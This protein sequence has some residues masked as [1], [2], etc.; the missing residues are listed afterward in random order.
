[1]KKFFLISVI[2]ITALTMLGLSSLSQEPN[3]LKIFMRAKLTHSQKL[4]EG[5]TT[6]NYDELAK[7]SQELALLSQATN[8]NV[9]MTKDYLQHSLEFRR[10]ASALTKAAQEKN[11]DGATLA[12]VDMTMKCVRCHQYVRGV[13]TADIRGAF[14]SDAISLHQSGEKR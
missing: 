3:D 8:W 9:L 14:N 4:I 1:M 10:A 7:H 2:G 6:E 11:L 13:R 5:L 12:Y